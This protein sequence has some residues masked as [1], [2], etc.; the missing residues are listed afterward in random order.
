MRAYHGH[1]SSHTAPQGS[2]GAIWMITE[3]QPDQ[4]RR[5]AID[6]RFRVPVIEWNVTSSLGP[7]PLAA[8]N[9]NA[10]TL[11]FS[12]SILHH[13]RGTR[14]NSYGYS[15]NSYLQTS[16]RGIFIISAISELNKDFLTVD[17][18]SGSLYDVIFTAL[19]SE[20]LYKAKQNEGG[21]AG[22]SD[23]GLITDFSV[24]QLWN[25]EIDNYSLE[26]KWILSNN[27]LD[28]YSTIFTSP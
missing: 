20:Y 9:P 17:R 8:F 15:F 27:P 21:P 25:S 12:F 18:L 10:V 22:A 24:I 19:S 4:L 26:A 2:A 1:H 7:C 28:D 6:F 14:E 23:F 11:R 3:H 5:T 13:C 16:S